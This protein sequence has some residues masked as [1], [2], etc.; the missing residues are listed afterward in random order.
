MALWSL[1]LSFHVCA[2]FTP[3]VPHSA[4]D[5]ITFDLVELLDPASPCKTYIGN[6]TEQNN[7]GLGEY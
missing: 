1:S 3:A 6:D 4:L 2:G 7:V 5:L